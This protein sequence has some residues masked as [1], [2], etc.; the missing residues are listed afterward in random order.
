MVTNTASRRFV[1]DDRA[2][3]AVIGFILIVGLLVLTLAVYQVQVVPQQNA[4]TEFEHF[5]DS[6]DELIEI[7]NSISIA[8][9]V[10]VSQFP[11]LKLGTTYQTRLLAINPPPPAGTVQTSESYNIT[12]ANET[13]QL[14]ITTRFLEYEPEYN[15]IEVGSTQFEHSVLYLDERSRDR[16]VSII[17]DQNI[18]DGETVRITALQN[19][20]QRSGTNRVTVELYPRGQIAADDFPDPDDGNFTVTVPTQLDADEYWNETLKE[21]SETYQ[22]VDNQ[23]HDDDTHALNLSVDSDDLEINTVGIRAEPNEGPA[24][25]TEP[26]SGTVVNG[27]EFSDLNASVEFGTGGNSDSPSGISIN[28]FE[29]AGISEGDTTTTF[30]ATENN[31]D[32][33]EA[34]TSEISDEDLT[35]DLGGAGNN[36]FP[37][38]VVANIDG[39][40]CL[41]ATFK[42][43]AEDTKTLDSGGWEQC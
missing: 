20:F 41:E 18:V 31:G 30:T 27:G 21:T 38:D 33:A 12:I 35:L 11:S 29:I 9:Q 42:E 5:E 39:G 4:Q 6:Q 8:G 34:T 25:N 19:G 15:E 36:E 14:N 10:D 13:D 17:E 26:G 3:S 7:R 24:K 23:A 32:T 1:A 40:Q 28:S 22:G 37:V 2:V 16:K 43:D